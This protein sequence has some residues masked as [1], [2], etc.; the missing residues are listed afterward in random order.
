MNKIDIPNYQK[1]TTSLTSPISDFDLSYEEQLKELISQEMGLAKEK[2]K[3]LRCAYFTNNVKPSEELAIQNNSFQYSAK[4]GFRPK[5]NLLLLSIDNL[6]IERDFPTIIHEVG[7]FLSLANSSTVIMEGC[8][9]FYEEKWC[10]N[11]N[12]LEEFKQKYIGIESYQKSLYLL[13]LIKNS[14]FK[15]NEVLFKESI[16]KGHDEQFKNIV[17]SYL[18]RIEC[19][20]SAEELFFLLDVAFHNRNNRELI[21]CF[22]EDPP[23]YFHIFDVLFQETLPMIFREEIIR[24]DIS[25]ANSILEEYKSLINSSFQELKRVIINSADIDKQLLIRNYQ[26]LLA[27]ELHKIDEKEYWAK[28]QQLDRITLLVDAIE[29]A[30]SNAIS[31]SKSANVKEEEYDSNR[32]S[33][34]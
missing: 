2:L 21:N 30:I 13:K 23:Y 34:I 4:G 19:T 9:L 24:E 26:V 32:F 20:F 27:K 15:N 10:Q 7:H 16:S 18:E 14:V 31:Q 8:A 5:D 22:K 33:R 28:T 12:R 6:D 3:D 11:N 29:S 17:D 1:I 25:K